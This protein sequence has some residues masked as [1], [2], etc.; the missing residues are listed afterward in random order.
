MKNS[1]LLQ[2]GLRPWEIE[3]LHREFPQYKTLISQDITGTNITDQDWQHVEMIYGSRLTSQQLAHA[4]V[5]RWIHSP[6]LSLKRLCLDEIASQG[7]I[8]VTTAS[9]ENAA[10]IGEFVLGAILAFS[11][12]LLNW[13]SAMRFPN[14]LWESKWRDSMWALP[15][16]MMVQVG[17]GKAGTEI[18]RCAGLMGIQVW[19]V[20]EKRTFHPHCHKTVSF[21]RLNG[22]LPT[23]DIVCLCLPRQE[24]HKDLFRT[25][26]LQLMKE[27]SILIVIGSHDSVNADDLAVVAESGKFRGIL[28]D[29]QHRPPIP[30]KSPLWQVPGILI[31]PDVS[32]RPRAAGRQAFQI[33]HYNLRQYL[34][35]NFDSMRNRI[36]FEL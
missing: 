6:T 36:S 33:F 25:E 10:Q 28:F 31:T 34:H 32:A 23:A 18:A 26:Q 30:L 35:G 16:K 21:D 12:H 3:Q 1:I 15:K 20:Q 8:L 4:P 2:V 22:I 17:L 27:D 19:G 29:A 5:L 13:Q 11:K 7:N 24:S 14:V 9:E